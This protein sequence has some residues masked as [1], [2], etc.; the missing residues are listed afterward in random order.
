MIIKNNW[1]YLDDDPKAKG[2]IENG[3][4]ITERYKKKHLFR[5]GN[6]YPIQ[7][8]ILLK[9]HNINTILIIEKNMGGNKRYI[10]TTGEYLK[11][12]EFNFGYG[13][14]RYIPLPKMRL[15]K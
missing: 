9:E 8:E 11:G 1:V 3:K 2:R 5:I 15:S 13:K 14:Q 7:V 10:S 4:Y 6:G 12:D